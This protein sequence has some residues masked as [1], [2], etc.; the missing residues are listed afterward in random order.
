MRKFIILVLLVPFL[1]FLFS[2]G[3]KKEVK[4]P[5]ME[6]LY[7]TE[8]FKVV[9]DIRVAYQNKDNAGIRKGCSESAFR[10]IIAS[11][12]SFDKADLE[13]TPVLVEME[14]D[15]IRL[16]VSWNGKWKYLGTETEERGLAT[17]LLKGN[18]P[19][20]EKILRGNPFRYPD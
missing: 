12:R 10:D 7:T 19:K 3:G 5:S 11:I 9:D 20:V 8:A 15:S 4:Q 18:P 14:G 6:Y 1:T 2:C 13:F 17:F 16:Y